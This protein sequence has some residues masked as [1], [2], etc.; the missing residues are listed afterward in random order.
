MKMPY[1]KDD[2]SFQRKN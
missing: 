2:A 1:V